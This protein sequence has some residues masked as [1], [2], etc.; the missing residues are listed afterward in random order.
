MNEVTDDLISRAAALEIINVVKSTVWSQSGQVLCGKMYSQIKNLPAVD[1][2][3]V[4]HGRWIDNGDGTVRCNW[5]A[6][7]LPKRRESQL[8]F[9]G[10]CG[11]KMDEKND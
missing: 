10:C 7:W 6:T 5:C 9:C 1:A 11:A 4:V 2:V 3:P 8:Q